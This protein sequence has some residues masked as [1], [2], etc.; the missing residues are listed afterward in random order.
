VRE[1]QRESGD[2]HREGESDGRHDRQQQA[3]ADAEPGTRH[4]SE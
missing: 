3:S 2:R 1:D 4:L